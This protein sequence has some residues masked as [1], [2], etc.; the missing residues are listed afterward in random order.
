MKK[1][2]VFILIFTFFILAGFYSFNNKA[3]RNKVSS[4]SYPTPFQN[5]NQQPATST[6]SAINTNNNSGAMT[7]ANVAKH[8]KKNDCYLAIQNK[9]YDVSSYISSHPGGKGKIISVCGQEVTG[10][11]ASIHSNFAWDLLKN[12]QIGQI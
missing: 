6:T 1:S 7:M 10:V 3:N 11:F 12:Y 4:P 8:N 2:A 5:N 9:V